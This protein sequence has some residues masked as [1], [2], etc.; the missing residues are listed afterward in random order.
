VARVVRV[1][2]PAVDLVTGLDSGGNRLRTSHAA[3]RHNR[4]GSVV[5]RSGRSEEHPIVVRMGDRRCGSLAVLDVATTGPSQVVRSTPPC[6]ENGHGDEVAGPLCGPAVH[7]PAPSCGHRGP[8]PPGSQQTARDRG[9]CVGV[10]ADAYGGMQRVLEVEAGIRA[11]LGI[12]FRDRCRSDRGPCPCRAVTVNPLVAKRPGASESASE[13]QPD[14][15]SRRSEGSRSRP[16][17][18]SKRASFT[19][20]R[21]ASDQSTQESPAKGSACVSSATARA[22]AAVRSR[23]AR[24]VRPTTDVRISAPFPALRLCRD[25]Y[26]R[27]ASLTRRPAGPVPRLAADR[28]DRVWTPMSDAPCSAHSRNASAISLSASSLVRFLPSAA[29]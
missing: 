12:Q 5:S 20:S 22:L 3:Q 18:T 2:E 25:A 27:A 1:D 17:A 10:V 23:S 26:S 7:D 14:Q 21:T 29:T 16:L 11:P 6:G 28:T 13:I 9:D 24:F 19:A 15:E 8:A 4:V